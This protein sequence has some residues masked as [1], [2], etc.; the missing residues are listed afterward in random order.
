MDTLDPL[1]KD[2]WEAN[3]NGSI[4]KSAK[5]SKEVA[6]KRKKGERCKGRKAN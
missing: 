5:E 6:K 4:R 2:H 3:N 1:W